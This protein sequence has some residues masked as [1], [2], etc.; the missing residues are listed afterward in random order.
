MNITKEL[1]E[2]LYLKNQYSASQIAEIIGIPKTTVKSYLRRL[3]IRKT[4]LMLGKKPYDNRDWLYE[5]YMVKQK[6]YTV[7]ADECRVSYTVIRDRILYFGWPL[8]GHKEIDKGAPRRGKKHTEESIKKIKSTRNKKRVIST[9][10]YCNKSLEVVQ[11]KFFISNRHFCNVA[12]F[13]NYLV[14]HRVETVNITDSAQYK[15]WR[16]SVYRRDGYRCK[17]PGCNSNSRDIAAHHIYP[18]NQFPDKQFE[19]TNGITLCRKCHE[20]T[21]GKESQFIEMLVRVVQK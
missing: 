14:K 15:E 3:G 2:N 4:E 6:G 10:S 7:I 20:K 18:K 1:L 13:H 12:C 21:Y 19:I 16:K 5:E 11:S 8:R 9:C 17:M